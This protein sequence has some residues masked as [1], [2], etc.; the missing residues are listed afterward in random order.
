MSLQEY[1]R[2]RRFGVTPEPRPRKRPGRP[3]STEAQPAGPQERRFVIQKHDASHIHYDLRL[4]LDG[5]LKSWACPKCLATPHYPRKLVMQVEDHPLE[6]LDFEGVIPAGEYGAGKVEIW[7]Q[8]VYQT[9]DDAAAGLEKGVMTFNLKGVKVRGE[10]TLVHMKGKGKAWL[11]LLNKP[12]RLNPDLAGTGSAGPMPSQVEPMQ[13]F[14]AAGPFD[15]A[16]HLFEVKLDGIRAVCYLRS[17]GR[18]SVR[19]RNNKEQAFR[20]PEF[21]NLGKLFLAREMVV[22]GEIV[23]LDEQGISRFQ[24]LQARINLSGETQ[25]KPA[26]KAMPARYFIFDLLYLDGRDLAGLPLWSRKQIL[27]RI[28]MPHKFLRRTDWLDTGGRAF[29]HAARELGL[30]G[31]MA[32]RKQSPYRQKRS[33]DWLK[34]KAVSEQEFV[35]GGYTRPL[36]SRSHFGALLLGF[37]EDGDLMYAGHV[38]TGFSE[39]ALSVLWR[40]MQPLKTDRPPFN[41]APR[42]NEPAQWI[43]PRLV[44]QIK[45]AEWT[46]DGRLRQ[47]VF[48][49]LREDI[50]PKNVVR[51]EKRLAG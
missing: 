7:D 26:G 32:K 42:S 17:D 16:E 41:I 48:L 9:Y 50:D 6:Y 44:A 39:E 40:R 30:E 35:I 33:R 49:G 14:L 24:L 1:E 18:V 10:F 43:R 34:I 37:Y 5:M 29:F 21:A 20:Y 19:S 4:E 28:F 12:E 15:S 46:R 13:A 25:I 11:I 22:D 45:F 27:E 38:G 3:G 36:G 8:G 23:A 51:E 47:P 2:R 31:V